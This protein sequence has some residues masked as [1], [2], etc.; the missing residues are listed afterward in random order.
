MAWD[1]V[2]PVTGCVLGISGIASG[3]LIARDGRKAER[4]IAMGEQ[5]VAHLTWLRERRASAYVAVLEFAF[6]LGTSLEVARDRGRKTDLPD[7]PDLFAHMRVLAEV[8]AY[9]SQSVKRC[10][11]RW[12]EHAV[13]LLEL[14][15]RAPTFG[16]G[17][18]YSQDNQI[19]EFDLRK[20]LVAA[21]SKELSALDL[22]TGLTAPPPRVPGAT[23]A[24]PIESAAPRADP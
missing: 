23:S 16:S 9:G 10:V 2:S 6:K 11:N 18:I 20:E 7:L 24:E 5:R 13:R 17:E 1:W 21:V 8:G 14:V 4:E 12:N 15:R 3:Y 22:L 19:V